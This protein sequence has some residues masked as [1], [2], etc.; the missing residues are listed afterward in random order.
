MAWFIGWNLVLARF[1]SLAGNARGAAIY[2]N[3][4][5]TK[6]GADLPQWML[7]YDFLDKKEE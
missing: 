1:I 4:L 5:L 7:G 2:F 6:F 3:G